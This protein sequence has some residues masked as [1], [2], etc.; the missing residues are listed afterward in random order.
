MGVIRLNAAE[1]RN[2][3]LIDA[4]LRKEKA[5]CPGAVALIGV[6]GSF[7][8]GDVHPLSDLDLLILISDSRGWQLGKAFI[9]EDLGIG[10][11]IY[12]TDWD[13]LRRD[14]GYNDP[15]IAKLMDSVIVYCADEKYL[16]ELEA[17]R[18]Q[19]RRI[20]AGPFCEEDYQKAE[21]SLKEA[22]FCYALAM[23]ADTLPEARRQAGGALY[24]AENAVALLNKTY[25]RK[26]VRRRYEEL[27]AMKK[28]P[29]DLCGLIEDVTAAETA[30]AL[31]E[32]LTRL[33]KALTLCFEREK[34]ALLP[35]KRPPDA[36]S[37]RGTYEEMF[38][39]W[40]GK[41]RVA[42]E[43]GD[44]HLAFMSLGSLNEMIADIGSDVDICRYD[45]L[46]V[47]DPGNLEKTAEGFDAVLRSYLREY[48]KAGLRPAVYRD[49][50]AFT[51]AYL[52]PADETHKTD[53]P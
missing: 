29:E 33:V 18:E 32:R 41:M 15:N 20:L 50:D 8:T 27:A 10:H 35:A 52:E 36:E 17:L 51:A 13:S 43:T 26:G 3:K 7:M 16:S 4:V 23:A 30:A 22:L 6:Y 24:H 1:I 53:A 31:K 42:A 21:S 38:S 2:T 19:V 12:C 47:Y 14:A 34:R 28:R 45:A 49:A 46:S 40:H 37:L 48:E 25:F 5:V 11:D 44:R 9:Q 39:N